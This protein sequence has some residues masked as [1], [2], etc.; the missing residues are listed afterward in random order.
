[1]NACKNL[2]SVFHA[3]VKRDTNLWTII[4]ANVVQAI[5]NMIEIA[6]HAKDY[7]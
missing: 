3:I 5:I 2:L 1:M 6:F 4:L 7:A